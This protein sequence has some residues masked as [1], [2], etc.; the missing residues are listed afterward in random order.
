MGKIFANHISNKGLISRIFRELLK[1]T[2]RQ[3]NSRMGKGF[4]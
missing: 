3:L 1:P 2:R 4:E